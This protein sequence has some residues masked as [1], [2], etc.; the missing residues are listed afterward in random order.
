MVDLYRQLRGWALVAQELNDIGIT[1]PG[2]GTWRS[3]F[4][5]RTSLRHAEQQGISLPK[6]K[7]SQRRGRPS[8]LSD[9]MRQTLW[10]M[11]YED[12]MSYIAIA[13]WLNDR[14]IKTASGK[15]Q[16]SKATVMYT[17]RVVERERKQV[18]R[19]RAA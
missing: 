9:A 15:S 12:G 16:W 1:R 8:Y 3:D 14:G 11:H 4:V 7:G 17:V 6:P 19:K 10:K 13:R 2:G 18:A 5:R